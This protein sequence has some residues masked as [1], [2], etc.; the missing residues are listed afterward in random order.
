LLE[1]VVTGRDRMGW[2]GF[3][4]SGS[5]LQVEG[6][7]ECGNESKAS[8]NVG[9]FSSGCTTGGPSSSAQLHRVSWLVTTCPDRGP[10]SFPQRIYEKFLSPG[11]NT[12]LTL[13]GWG[14]I[15]ISS[16][17]S[18]SVCLDLF[19]RILVLMRKI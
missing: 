2:Y 11:R 8:I 9:K 16:M 12:F 6:S 4:L 3:D 1:K 18:W 5:G 19:S 13:L 15:S 7:C 17:M 10:S 14:F